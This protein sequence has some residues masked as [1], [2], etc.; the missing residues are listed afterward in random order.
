VFFTVVALD[1]A[2]TGLDRLNHQQFHWK[3]WASSG[4][5]IAACILLRPDG[6]ILLAALGAYL[7]FLAAKHAHQNSELRPALTAAFV[8]SVCALAPLAPW[9]IRNFRTLH[10]FQPLAPRY[11][12][13]QDELAARGFN[14]WVRTWIVDYTSVEEIYWNVPGDKIDPDKLPWRV[15]DSPAQRDATLALINDYN[16]SNEISADLDARFNEL[17]AQRIREHPV[18]YWVELPALRISDMWLRP[19]TELLPSDPRWWEF[20]DAFRGSITAVSVG[21]L[22][23][24]YIGAALVAVFWRFSAIRYAGLL[25][26][27]VALRS[28]FLGTIEN[29]EPRYTLECYPVVMLLASALFN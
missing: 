20:N 15:F 29:P 22:N 18:R 26:A 3:D 24:A 28:A 27:F 12:T 11:A 25:L 8:V 17:A 1:C 21:L 2:A 13:T 10:H 6:G 14:R 23:L 4:F 16:Q 19:R 9:T 7:V 5:A